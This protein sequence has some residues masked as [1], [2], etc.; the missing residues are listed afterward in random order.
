MANK[1]AVDAI[2]AAIDEALDEENIRRA[3]IQ[4]EHLKS[5]LEPMTDKEEE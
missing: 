2:L 3:K 1:D 4:V 5:A